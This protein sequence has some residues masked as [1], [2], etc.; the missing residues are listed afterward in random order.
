MENSSRKTACRIEL[1]RGGGASVKLGREWRTLRAERCGEDTGGTRS[2]SGQ[3]TLAVGQREARPGNRKV[4]AD[5]ESLV[6]KLG[7]VLRLVE[8]V[9]LT[10]IVLD[11]DCFVVEIKLPGR[12][13]RDG[14][15]DS[16]SS[17]PSPL[18]PRRQGPCSW[19]AP[20]T[21]SVLGDAF[22]SA[23]WGGFVARLATHGPCWNDFRVQNTVL[24]STMFTLSQL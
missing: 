12:N 19:Q 13:G 4:G 18:E 1:E 6:C 24:L 16:M 21:E 15:R 7:K 5:V 8:S 10:W 20:R 11:S 3:D 17:T 22:S 14:C 23:S 9:A 2:G